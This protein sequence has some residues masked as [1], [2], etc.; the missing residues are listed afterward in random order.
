MNEAE[1]TVWEVVLEAI[2]VFRVTKDIAVMRALVVATCSFIS[3]RRKVAAD[4]NRWW[5]I[6]V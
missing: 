1:I 2:R 3:L 6:S 5:A 4:A